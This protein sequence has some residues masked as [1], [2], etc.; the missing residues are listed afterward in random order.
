MDNNLNL[1][2]AQ[3]KYLISLYRLSS[4]EVGV[5]NVE[6]ANTLGYSKPSV[7]NMLRSLTELGLIRQEFFGLAFLTNV[8]T[9]LAQKYEFCYSLIEKKMAEIY[10]AGTASENAICTLL[11]DMPMEKI[12]ELY[13]ANGE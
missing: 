9:E 12:D 6:L 11:A 5:K 1:T 13:S 2:F 7:H 3:I 8:G 4:G 10:G